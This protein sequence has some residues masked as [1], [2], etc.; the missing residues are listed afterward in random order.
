MSGFREAGQTEKQLH[1]LIREAPPYS[2]AADSAFL[3]HIMPHLRRRYYL[4]LQTHAEKILQFITSLSQ[5][6]H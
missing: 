6:N 2:P 5:K 3:Y 1:L 4:L